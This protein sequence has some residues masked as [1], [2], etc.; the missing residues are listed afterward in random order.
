MMSDRSEGPD[1]S[2][3]SICWNS[4]PAPSVTG[5]IQSD[6]VPTDAT[7]WFYRFVPDQAE[8]GPKHVTV[9]PPLIVNRGSD[10][11]TLPENGSVLW[12]KSYFGKETTTAGLKSFPV[13]AC[14]AVDLQITWWQEFDANV[15]H[16][17]HLV[18][19][20]TFPL[21]VADPSYVQAIKMPT[22]GSVT[23]LPVCGGYSSSGAPSTDM[24]DSINNLI[25]QVQA[26]QAA[27]TKWATPPKK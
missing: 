18:Q 17:T 10:K 6:V 12:A 20:V 11:P 25:K 4:L 22:H 24:A 14:R 16:P 23:L 19:L 21:I 13:T 26:I 3:A 2:V 8:T 5:V 27:Q 7:G 1:T 9:V 15:Q